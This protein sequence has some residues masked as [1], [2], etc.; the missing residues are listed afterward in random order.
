MVD[1]PPGITRQSTSARSLGGADLDRRRA[2]RRRARE[3]A[4]GSHPG[5]RGRRLSR[6]STLRRLPAA[7]LE[8]TASSPSLLDLE[9]GHRVA[10]AARDLRQ[11]VGSRSAWSP[12]RS[13]APSWRGS[14]DLKMPEP[15]EHAVDAELHH[16]R[17]VGRRGDAAGGEVHDR[18]ACPCSATIAHQLDRRA[19]LLRLRH[20]LLGP[21]RGQPRRSRAGS[22]ARDARPRRRC[23]CRPRPSCGSSRRPRRCGAAPHP[24]C[25]RR[26]RT[27]P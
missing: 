5:A 12:R 8:Q 27:A 22:C 15:D 24:G 14:S 17:G 6:W 7:G 20:V 4:H 23:R 1:S 18:A 25:A 11:H 13:R 3:R 16:Q 10:E 19:E 21:Q 26:T 9:T 2:G